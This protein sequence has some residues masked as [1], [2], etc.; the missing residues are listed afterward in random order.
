[1]SDQDE[2]SAEGEGDPEFGDDTTLFRRVHPAH[3]KVE[4]GEMRITS[5]AF[6]NTTDTQ[7]M[8]VDIEE[9]LGES[10]L[11]PQDCLDGYEGFGLARFDVGLCHELD[12]IVRSS[13]VEGNPA[14]GDVIGHKTR[15]TMRQFASR[16]SLEIEP[17]LPDPGADPD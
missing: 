12:Q 4:N 2:E 15:T 13:P 10:D 1:M 7:N 6:R 11:T 3:F 17:A 16:S 5:A 14:H 8:S 9:L